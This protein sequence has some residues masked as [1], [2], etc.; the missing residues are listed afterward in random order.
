MASLIEDWRLGRYSELVFIPQPFPPLTQNWLNIPHCVLTV[1][2]K[3][4]KTHGIIPKRSYPWPPAEPWRAPRLIRAPSTFNLVSEA[5]TNQF[6]G[7]TLCTATQWK[8]N[9]HPSRVWLRLNYKTSALPFS[10][11][12]TCIESTNSSNS[13]LSLW[14]LTQF[15]VN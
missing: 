8:H 12:N 4:Q 5:L 9:R 11:V 14:M 3:E 7:G 13:P 10:M 15:F 1:G 2:V 6:T